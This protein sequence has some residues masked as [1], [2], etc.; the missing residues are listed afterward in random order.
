MH[1]GAC[2]TNSPAPPDYSVR[3]TETVDEL[4]SVWRIDCLAYGEDNVPFE[5]L[6]GWW[7]HCSQGHLLIETRQGA[8]VGGLG[9]WPVAQETYRA[10]RQGTL[11]EN[12]LSVLACPQAGAKENHGYL[13]GV[14][15]AEPHRG[16]RAL[17]YLVRQA[18]AQW[19]ATEARGAR[20]RIGALA[21]SEKGRRLLARLGFAATGALRHRSLFYEQTLCAGGEPAE[22][23][24]ANLPARE[25]FPYCVDAPI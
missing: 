22:P 19:R 14:A 1:N 8:V 25:G 11:N 13:S 15:L 3:A 10:L 6:L 4:L 9:L 16:T 5:V 20:T 12:D 18:S 24:G 23:M 17:F 21:T 7:E 2:P